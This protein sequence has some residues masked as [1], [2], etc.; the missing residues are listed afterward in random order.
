MEIHSMP[1]HGRGEQTISAQPSVQE[2]CV[3]SL[4]ALARL[5]ASKAD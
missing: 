2:S 1:V 3:F 5:F 4:V